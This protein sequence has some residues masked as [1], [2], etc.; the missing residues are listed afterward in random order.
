MESFIMRPLQN[1]AAPFVVASALMALAAQG[2]VGQTAYPSK[3][4]KIVIG[5]PA[6][7]VVDVLA[8]LVANKLQLGQPVV[9]EG[10]TGAGG[11]I[12]ADHVAKAKPDGYTLLLA[13]N[14]SIVVNQSLYEKLPYDPEKD[15]VPISQIAATPNVLVVHPELPIKTVQELVAVA[16]AKPDS[17]TYAHA[18]VGISHH[19]GAELFKQMAAID[20][21]AVGYRGGPALFS[22]LVAGRVDLCFCNIVTTL[23]LAKE[24]KLRA[25]AITSA[26]RSPLAPD[27]PTMAESGFA[28]FEATAWFGLLAPTG[29]PMELVEQL[30]RETARVLA[31]PDL[32]KSFDTLGM[33]AIGNSPAAFTAAIKAEAPYWR[34]L[35]KAIGLK[36]E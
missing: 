10:I 13:G 4:V 21:R 27:L 32:R 11:N 23:P 17:L 19:L 15:L 33:T 3:P 2:A 18:G 16:R 14:A 8:R 36:V 31:D 35:I 7:S 28:G 1:L 26:Q 30:H 12:A 34:K 20:I 5:F 6:G 25:L 9:V 24:G 29:T 22:D